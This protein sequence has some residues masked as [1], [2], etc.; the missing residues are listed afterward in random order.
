MNDSEGKSEC[1]IPTDSQ[2]ANRTQS[3]RDLDDRSS[4]GKEKAMP[5]N[6]REDVAHEDTP[7]S[8]Q[9]QSIE[10]LLLLEILRELRD[11]DVHRNLHFSPQYGAGSFGQPHT[12]PTSDAPLHSLPGYE[13]PLAHVT[14]VHYHYHF[15]TPNVSPAAPINKII[16]TINNQNTSNGSDSSESRCDEG[17]H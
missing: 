12:N 7:N 11:K 16:V 17:E 3:I 13:I 6:P 2:H 15:N 4:K 5:Q 10:V 1:N 9:T 14:E 8:T